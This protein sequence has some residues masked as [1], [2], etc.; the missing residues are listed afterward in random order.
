MKLKKEREFKFSY[1]NDP[2]TLISVIGTYNNKIKVKG[3]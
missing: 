2:I 3:E 1:Y